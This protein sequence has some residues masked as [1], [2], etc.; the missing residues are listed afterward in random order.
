LQD[1]GRDLVLGIGA[2]DE[3]GRTIAGQSTLRVTEPAVSI[4][5]REISAGA[6]ARYSPDNQ[7]IEASKLSAAHRQSLS[8]REPLWSQPFISPA[9]GKIVGIF[10]QQQVYGVFRPDHPLPGVEI[11]T[12]G[13]DERVRASNA[14]VVAVAEELPIR[15]KT[16]VLVHGGGIVT[17]YANLGSIEVVEGDRVARGQVLGSPKPESLGDRAVG[18]EIHVAGVPSNPAAWVNQLLPSSSADAVD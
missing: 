5:P 4:S 7:R 16:V 2:I 8:L 9:T 18:V 1:A 6:F 14:G 17:V 11:A 13:E 3:Y 10:G 15:G 12:E